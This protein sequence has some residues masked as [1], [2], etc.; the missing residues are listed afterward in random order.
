VVWLLVPGWIAKRHL[1]NRLWLLTFGSGTGPVAE[2]VRREAG[3]P[4]KSAMAEFT[5]PT[6]TGARAR[7]VELTSNNQLLTEGLHMAYCPRL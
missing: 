4:G 6:A 5:H 2:P 3:S 1:M 7:R